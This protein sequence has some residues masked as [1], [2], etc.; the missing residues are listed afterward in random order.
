MPFPLL[1]L[2]AGAA[3]LAGGALANYL[4]G[5]GGGESKGNFLTGYPA[6]T[7][8]FPRFTPQQQGVQNQALQQVLSYLQSGGKGAQQPGLF[9]GFN[10]APIAQQARTQFNQQ[11]IPSI[12]ERFTSMG[13]GGSQRSSAFQSALGRAGSDL[14]QGLAA[15][16]SKYNLAQGGQ[17]NQL[18]QLL[19]SLGMQPSFES[20]YTPAQPGLVQSVAPA[21]GQLGSLAGLNYLG[22]L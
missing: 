11:T 14:E 2:A 17:N 20:A 10:F 21:L 9:G 4:G 7:Q 15:L 5:R 6:Q 1:P 12:A 22:L 13:T 19:L 18:L 16:E 3:G 8:Q